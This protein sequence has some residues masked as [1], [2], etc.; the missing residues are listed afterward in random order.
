MENKIKD[1]VRVTILMPCFNTENYIKHAI[2][3]I[4]LQSFLNF[5]LIIIDDYSTDS[6]WSIISDIAKNNKRI[7]CLKNNNKKGISGAINTGLKLANSEYITRM[8]SDDISHPQ[9]IEKQVEFLDKNE[10]YGIC[11]VNLCFINKYGLS[12]SGPL[13]TKTNVPLEWLFLWRNPIANAPAM[14]RRSIIQSYD[15]LYRDLVVA[16]DYDFLARVA[17][18]TKVHQIDEVLYK[19]R[20]TSDGAFL[21][22]EET[23]ITNSIKTCEDYAKY[24]VGEDF[25]DFHKFISTYETLSAK[26]SLTDCLP[27]IFTYAGKL[28]LSARRNWDW[29]DDEYLLVQKDMLSRIMQLFIKEVRD[30]SLSARVSNMLSPKKSHAFQLAKDLKDSVRTWQLRNRL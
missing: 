10:N 11:S 12:T 15:I 18:H 13:F 4:L 23:A 28:L 25:N 6:T 16:E 2:N 19:Y 17:L 24:L 14:V 9:R 30:T 3:S 1:E 5:E 21:S 27:D 29:S 26:T 7:K 8:D 22:N 20:R